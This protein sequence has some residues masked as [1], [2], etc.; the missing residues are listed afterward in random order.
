MRIVCW[1]TYD[2][3]K[4]RVRILL[5]GLQENNIEVI[6][7]HKEVWGGIKDKSQ[8][9][10]F[11]A[12]LRFAAKWKHRPDHDEGVV[13]VAGE[14]LPRYWHLPFQASQEA[15]SVSKCSEVFSSRCF[16]RSRIISSSCRLKEMRSA[17]SPIR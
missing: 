2:I 8:I 3:G 16:T 13:V 9:A 7:C 4:P 12:K 11:V 17:T 10:G 1:G 14:P 5:R 15:L 6:E